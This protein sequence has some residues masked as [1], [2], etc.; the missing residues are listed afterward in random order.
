MRYHWDGPMHMAA[1]DQ[2]AL[3]MEVD[4]RLSA[5]PGNPPSAVAQG[6]QVMACEMLT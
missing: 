2:E 5:V 4:R 3:L 1:G 6:I